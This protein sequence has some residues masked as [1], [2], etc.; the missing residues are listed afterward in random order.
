MSTAAHTLDNLC[1]QEKQKVFEML[2]QLNELKKRCTSLEEDIGS[3]QLECERLSGREEIIAKQLEET[4]A[5]LFAALESSK[6]S[7]VKIDE[8]S[9]RLQKSDSER[10]AVC[11]QYRD[12]QGETQSLRDT[13]RQLRSASGKILVTTSVQCRIL[14][15]DKAINTE[16]SA[17][18]MQNTAVQTASGGIRE[19]EKPS[20][21]GKIRAEVIHS[22]A[23]PRLPH[24]ESQ[25]DADDELEQLISI[26]NP[27]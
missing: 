12:L 23:D 24:T 21:S 16:N 20:S 9:L 3:K 18:N 4:Q 7:Q 14:S 8:L 13:I 15:C 17:L 5:K 25:L 10:K 19:S 26:L 2:R 22:R 1:K 6:D 27:F 11:I